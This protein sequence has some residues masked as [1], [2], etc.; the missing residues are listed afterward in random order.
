MNLSLSLIFLLQAGTKARFHAVQELERDKNSRGD[1][2]E[3]EGMV[4]ILSSYVMHCIM[5]AR[6][7]VLYLSALIAVTIPTSLS[8]F[9]TYTTLK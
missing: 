2:C 6:D 5:D 7:D 3:K 1:N 9:P 8:G 4:K